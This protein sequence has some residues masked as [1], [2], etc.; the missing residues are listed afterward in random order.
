MRVL[1][2]GIMAAAVVACGG[3]AK[4]RDSDTATV[5]FVKGYTEALRPVRTQTYSLTV[6]ATCDVLKRDLYKQAAFIF[7]GRTRKSHRV[8]A[9]APVEVSGA[10]TSAMPTN[11]RFAP[12]GSGVS[13][14]YEMDRTNCHDFAA[15]TVEG[16]HAYTVHQE[17]QGE[18]CVMRVVDDA[19]A[20]PPPGLT[21][22]GLGATQADCGG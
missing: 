21:N 15:F 9:G 19:T 1:K 8:P 16:G 22:V 18:R 12:N 13:M 5:T 2:V 17:W 7:P 6:R 4:G 14:S 10:M 3:W 11:M 20:Q